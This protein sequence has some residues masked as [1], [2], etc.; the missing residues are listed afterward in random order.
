[1]TMGQRVKKDNPLSAAVARCRSS[2]LGVGVFSFAINLFML[3]GPLF[4]LQ[5]YDRVLTSRSIPTLVALYGLVVALYASLGLFNFLRVR[6]LS[7]IGF[8]LDSDL[9]MLAEKRR[10]VHGL[11]GGGEELRPVGDLTRLRQFVASPALTALFDLPWTPIYLAVVFYM[12]P[13]LGWLATGGIVVITLFTIANEALTKPKVSE[14]TY[15]DMESARFSDGSHRNADVIVSMGMLQNTLNYW[16]KMRKGGMVNSQKAGGVTEAMTSA[17]KA[18]RLLLQSSI[19]ALGAY[20]AVYQIITPGVMIAASIIGGRALAPVDQVVGGW[21]NFIAARQSYGRLKAGLE[22]MEKSDDMLQLPAPEGHVSFAAV[23]KMPP[24]GL[25]DDG[26]PILNGISFVLKPGDAMG[27]IGPSASGKSSLARILVGL[28]MPDR[29]AARLDGATLDQW[30]S[31]ELGKHIGYLPQSVNLMRGTIAENIS[32]FD[33][34]AK[35]EDIVE[36]AKLANVNELILALPGG[37]GAKIDDGRLVLSGGQVQRIALARA[38]YGRPA[39]IVLDEPNSNLDAEGDAALSKAIAALREAGNTIIVMA[40]RPSAIASVNMLLMLRGGQQ[41]DFGPK[42]EVLRRVT[43]AS[44]A[45]A[46]GKPK[47][48][49]RI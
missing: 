43:E 20:L 37:Y 9:M 42:E 6:V 17:S 49:V 29:G 16:A 38:V 41:V 23:T 3:T 13:W 32:R 48:E 47:L 25:A 39:L 26:A 8:R 33:P 11:I 28:W 27:V 44:N 5:V 24:K 14:A 10:I 36:A 1:M 2:F 35:D 15:W 31:D 21:R 22:H 46:I 45:S 7:R 12:H 34:D 4:M 19:L 40:H 18:I 30:D